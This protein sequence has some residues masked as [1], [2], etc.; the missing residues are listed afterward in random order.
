MF[1]R[2]HGGMFLLAKRQWRMRYRR[3]S[4]M[5]RAPLQFAVTASFLLVRATVGAE[6]S[7]V[8]L[9]ILVVSSAGN[10]FVHLGALQLRSTFASR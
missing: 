4:T 9:A 1:G 2:W 8:P 6:L 5:L 10:T 3:A 7:E